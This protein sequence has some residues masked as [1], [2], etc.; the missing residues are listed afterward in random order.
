MPTTDLSGA[1]VLVTGATGQVGWGAARAAADA[2]AELILPTRSMRGA[3]ALRADFPAAEVVVTDLSAPGASSALAAVLDR[4]GRLDHV[5]A[6]LGSWWQG[7]TSIDQDANELDELLA[8]YVSAQFRL[9]RAS[10]SLLREAAG[11][12]TLVTGAAGEMLIPGA[13]LLVVAVRAQYALA[14][15]LREEL[16]SDRIRFNEFRIMTRIERSS[17]PGVITSR[18]AGDAFVDVLTGAARSELVRYPG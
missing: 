9:L 12:Y 3:S 13:G 6:P 4:S 16:R 10:A 18:E 5:V 17:R 15:V 14:D 8:T 2:G 7:G 1:V 11:S